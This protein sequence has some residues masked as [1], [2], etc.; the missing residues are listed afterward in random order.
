VKTGFEVEAEAERDGAWICR[1]GVA[2]LDLVYI[3]QLRGDCHVEIH[4]HLEQ[5]SCKTPENAQNQVPVRFRARM[6]AVKRLPQT[7]PVRLGHVRCESQKQ[8][9]MCTVQTQR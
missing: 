8:E 9:C 3:L 4:F 6:N 1:T 5:I 2:S 7:R